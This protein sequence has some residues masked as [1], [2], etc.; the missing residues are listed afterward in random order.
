[1]SNF[2]PFCGKIVFGNSVV[3]RSEIRTLKWWQG[4]YHIYFKISSKKILFA[5]LG[6]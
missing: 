4:F 6:A 1:M 3:V 2:A 5:K